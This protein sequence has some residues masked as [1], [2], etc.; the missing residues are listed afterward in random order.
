LLADSRHITNS[1]Y[2]CFDVFS[3]KRCAVENLKKGKMHRTN[4]SIVCFDVISLRR[5]AVESLKIA[6]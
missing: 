3:R 4:S 5:G 2:I 6:T 1:E